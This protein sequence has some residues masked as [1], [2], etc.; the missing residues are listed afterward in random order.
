MIKKTSDVDLSIE[1]VRE[2]KVTVIVPKLEAYVTE[3][4][5]YAPSKAPVFYNPVMELNRDISV[6]AFQA[7]QR[8]RSSE[9]KICEPLTSS[10]IRGIRYATEIQGVEKVFIN[11]INTKAIKLA[12]RNIELNNLQDKIIVSHKDANC[13]LSCHGKPRQR[14]D[15]VDLDPFGTPAPYMD[16]A[17]RA[18]RND[19]LLSL[20]AT[21]L[22]CLCGV[23]TRACIRKY[24]G[25]P[26]RT[27]YCHELA[28]R[29]LIGCTVELA[30][31]HD[32]GIH[33][34][35]S[36]ST[37]HYVRV[38]AEITHGAKRSDENLRNMGYILHCFNCLHRETTISLFNKNM[39]CPECGSQLDFAGP[40]WLGN[41]LDKQFCMAMIKENVYRTFR[42]SAR[43]MKLLS[44][45]KDEAEETS[46]YYVLDKLSAKLGLPAPSV[47]SV[48]RTLKDKGFHAVQTH[49]NTR[50]IRTNAPA[51]VM[52]DLTEV[53]Q[54]KSR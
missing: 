15:I 39:N 26:L 29:L 22:A 54:V 30:A 20:T 19:G 1:K 31:K 18:L 40:L 11:D 16:S 44:L 4:S 37:D 45:I 14:F 42:S 33:V 12:K 10:G 48:L 34:V 25:K 5:E 23:H 32:I 49:F 46:T 7:Y 28:V 43:I 52:Q 6:L 35:F 13:L 47:V 21:D 8:K 3:P 17:I 9:I 51:L 24:G 41:L 50:G 27:E 2:G 38:Y 36:H 53:S